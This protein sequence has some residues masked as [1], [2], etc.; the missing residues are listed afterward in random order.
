MAKKWIDD[1]AYIYT[2]GEYVRRK[3]ASKRGCKEYRFITPKPGRRLLLCRTDKKKWKAI[4]LLRDLDLDPKEVK[5]PEAR[6]ELQKAKKIKQRL[7]EI[8]SKVSEDD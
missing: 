3:L 7:E 8:R 1:D 4:A 2:Q 5:D 6:V